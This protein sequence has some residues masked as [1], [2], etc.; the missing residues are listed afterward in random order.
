MHKCVDFNDNVTSQTRRV[1]LQLHIPYE[2][3]YIHS[4]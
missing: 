3:L 1:L 2:A 4:L